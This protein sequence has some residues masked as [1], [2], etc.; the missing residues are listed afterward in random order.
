MKASQNNIK[1]SHA[2]CFPSLCKG[3]SAYST[4]CNCV[5]C[6]HLFQT[7]L[8]S[9][10]ECCGSLYLISICIGYSY[11]YIYGCSIIN[12]AH[13]IKKSLLATSPVA[14]WAVECLNLNGCTKMPSYIY[15]KRPVSS[16]P[17]K[18]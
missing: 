18:T 3:S 16:Q 4:L 2:F 12:I 5:P 8:A 15:P 7:S 9:S 6:I 13:G 10:L 1:A 11:S 14:V 17:V